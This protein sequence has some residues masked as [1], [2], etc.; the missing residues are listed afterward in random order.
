MN[1]DVVRLVLEAIRDRLPS[2]ALDAMVFRWQTELETLIEGLAGSSSID[3]EPAPVEI[4]W[5]DVHPGDRVLAPNGQWYT[6]DTVARNGAVVKALLVPGIP[7]VRNA[8]DK[9]LAE[10]GD[11]GKAVDVFAAA[12]MTLEAIR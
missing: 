11:T 4:R 9:V 5:A 6:V 7:T 10:R 12:G 1:A 2:D 3:K 8:E